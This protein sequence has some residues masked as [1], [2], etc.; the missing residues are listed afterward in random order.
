MS[1]PVQ[2]LEM[3]VLGLPPD[4]RAHLLEKLSASFE[5]KSK[6]QDAWLQLALRRQTEVRSGKVTMVHGDVA[7]ER[8]RTRVA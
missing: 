5:P 4:D 7:L 3:Q 1:M 2:D 6:A 8:V